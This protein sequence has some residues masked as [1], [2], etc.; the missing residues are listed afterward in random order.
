MLNKVVFFLC[1]FAGAMAC[2][3]K[4]P[5]PEAASAKQHTVTDDLGRQVTLP[6]EPRRILALAP[7]MTE[8]LFAVA[9][10][11]TIIAR[12]QNCDF[13]AAALRKPLLINYPMDYE[14]LLFLKPDVVFAT[15]G[16]I[17]LEVTA[18]I[19]KLG[20]PVYYQ[21]YDSVADVLRGLTDLGRILNRGP[22][23]RQ[24]VDSLQ[25]QLNLLAADTSQTQAPRVL[26]I[27]WQDPIYAYGQNT[28]FTDKLR[29]AGG[30]NAVQQVFAQTHP[31]LTREYILQINPQV[32]LGGTLPELEK[33]FFSLYPELRRI[34]AYRQKRI[35]PFTDDLMSRPSPRVVESILE[36]KQALR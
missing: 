6:L 16:I 34:E 11:A 4:K 36:I 30:Q 20:I 23:A 5:A 21:A 15:E 28:L 1:F 3:S 33:S 32:V 31:A 19:E 18:Q 12:T 26:A 35:F 25:T 13:P 22:Q 17:S 29:Y 14:R 9:D 8:M 10:T 2:E 24:L 7:S 27:T